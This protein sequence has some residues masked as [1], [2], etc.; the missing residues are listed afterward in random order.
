M[1]EDKKRII[2]IDELYGV[3]RENK[4]DELIIDLRPASDYRSA[5]IEDSV[6]LPFNK[7][8]ASSFKFENVKNVYLICKMGSE[9]PMAAKLISEIYPELTVHY[10]TV[11]GL[12][13]WMEKKYPVIF[14][15][16]KITLIKNEPEFDKNEPDTQY[17]KKT[18]RLIPEK[19]REL[20]RKHL[21]S[22]INIY[23]FE[24]LN[25]NSYLIVNLEKK[26]A[27]VIVVLPI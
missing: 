22:F 19:K 26:E 1:K 17:I 20:I 8:Q 9:S 11:G 24:N 14:E 7:L 4:K 2:S 25:R 6:N 15:E 10:I 23:H 16:K 27:I 12:D 3:Y 13:E 21:P 18:T 5:H